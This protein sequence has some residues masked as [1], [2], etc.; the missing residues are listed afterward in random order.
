[1]K[2]KDAKKIIQQLAK[3]EF[4]LYP[5]SFPHK[6]GSLTECGTQN[7]FQWAVNM[8]ESRTDEEIERDFKLGLHVN[9]YIAWAFEEC[10]NSF[11][12]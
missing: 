2:I 6:D 11:L 10:R 12:K 8:W 9:N 4:V 1:M 5:G 7:V 3:E